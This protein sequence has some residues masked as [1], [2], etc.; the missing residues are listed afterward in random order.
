MAAAH[1]TIQFLRNPVRRGLIPSLGA[2]RPQILWIGCSS[3]GFAETRTLEVLPEE[4]IVHRNIGNILT[5][6]DLSTESSI[7]YALRVLKVSFIVQGV[8]RMFECILKVPFPAGKTYRCLRALRL[9]IRQARYATQPS[10]Q[11]VKVSVCSGGF[12]LQHQLMLARNIGELYESH[13]SELDSIDGTNNRCRWFAELNAWTQ[14]SD[15]MR[16][17][18]VLDAMQ[19]SGLKVHAFMYSEEDDS[20]FE[21]TPEEPRGNRSSMKTSRGR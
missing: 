2:A 9:Q 4:I 11:M 16:K 6:H 8:S 7:E 5:N 12:C 21:L 1:N 20:C 13:K 14:A 15:L 18:N 17:E 19:D 10:R 3:S